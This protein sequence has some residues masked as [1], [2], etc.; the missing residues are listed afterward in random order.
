MLGCLR[1]LSQMIAYEICLSTSLSCLMFVTGSLD[2]HEI[3]L[4]QADYF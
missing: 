2:I 4:F 3:V 1:A